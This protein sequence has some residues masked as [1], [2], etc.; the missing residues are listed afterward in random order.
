MIEKLGFF[1]LEYRH[2]EPFENGLENGKVRKENLHEIPF[3]SI[4]KYCRVE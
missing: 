4:N 1:S 2:L 3:R